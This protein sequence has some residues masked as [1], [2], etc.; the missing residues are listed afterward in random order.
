MPVQQERELAGTALGLRA[1]GGRGKHGNQLERR[2]FCACTAGE[3]LAG[4][5]SAWGGGKGQEESTKLRRRRFNIDSF[6]DKGKKATR[7]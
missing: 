6:H 7:N 3:E 4:R 2:P 5:P 1:G